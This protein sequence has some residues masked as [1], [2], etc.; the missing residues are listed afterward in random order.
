ML[1]FL[2][3]CIGAAIKWSVELVAGVIVEALIFG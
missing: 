2:F 1:G 3:S